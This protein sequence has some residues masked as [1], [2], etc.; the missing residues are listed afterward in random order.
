[1]GLQSLEPRIEKISMVTLIKPTT[2]ED[3][4][5]S[6]EEIQK[7]RP[8]LVYKTPLPGRKRDTN[9]HPQSRSEKESKKLQ[10]E[11]NL[12]LH[13]GSLSKGGGL[14]WGDVVF[15]GWR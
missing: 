9:N 15:F 7:G 1:L 10:K 5:K 4:S 11:K 3:V 8:S 6:R 13:E 12:F 14:F 2:K